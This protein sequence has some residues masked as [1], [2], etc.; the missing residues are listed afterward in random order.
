MKI[1][2]IECGYIGYEL[3]RELKKKGHFITCTSKNPCNI[4][5]YHDVQKALV[6]SNRDLKEM[7]LILDENDLIIV[8]TAIS[9]QYKNSY[10]QIA[11][12]IK[13]CALQLQTPK[14]IIFISDCTIY[15]HHQ[16]KWVDESSSLNAT[17]ENSK[18]L[19]EA[20]KI[21]F[22][23]FEL[24][25]KIC[26]LRIAKIY[27]PGQTL[28]DLLKPNLN[29]VIPGHGEYYTNM[30]HQK[31]VIGVILYILEHNMQGVFNVVDD[32]HPTR[33]DFANLLYSKLKLAPPKFDPAIAE[34]PEYNK[35]VSNYRIKEMGYHFKFPTKEI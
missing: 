6:M 3:A 25:W 33:K 9:V 4:K 14:K 24:D 28:F 19:I 31:D 8:T 5:H 23:L 30:V 12:T 1:A 17:D 32:D 13:N 20:E 10:H 22:S 35:R 18:S 26:I 27:G 15:G 34:F 16:G 2:I 29:E 11:Q 21:I 7:C